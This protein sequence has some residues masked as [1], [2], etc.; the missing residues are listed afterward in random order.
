M[1]SKKCT[2]LAAGEGTRPTVHRSRSALGFCENYILENG[3]R[4]AR[5]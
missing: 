5:I 2:A 4:F 1:G 3:T